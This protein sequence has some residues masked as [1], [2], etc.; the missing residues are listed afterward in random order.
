MDLLKST[1]GKVVSG[2]VGLAVVVGGIT[3]W[4][5]PVETRG[6]ILA[7]AGRILAWLGV[8]VVGP[9]ALVL[10]VGWVARRDNNSAG[11]WLV[12]GVTVG[13]AVLLAW[14]LGWGVSGAAG[15]TFFLLG[16]L[17]AGAYNL[18]IF[19]WLAEQVR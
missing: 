4:Q 1:T 11:A 6:A 15:W 2:V 12:G 13:E 3:W 5:T 7:A 9:W 14:L 16:V 10:V 19:D 17:V 8:V 18:L